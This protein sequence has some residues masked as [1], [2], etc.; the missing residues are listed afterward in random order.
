MCDLLVGLSGGLRPAGGL[1][2]FFFDR[3]SRKAS[4]DSA[5]GVDIRDRGGRRAGG[6]GGTGG[7]LRGCWLGDAVFGGCHRGEVVGRSRLFDRVLFHILGFGLEGLSAARGEYEPAIQ[8]GGAPFAP[9]AGL[10][11][12]RIGHA[13]DC[14]AQTDLLVADK[15]G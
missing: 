14:V 1:V 5:D 15:P 13:L 2:E 10:N 6:A 7:K 9:H 8:S 11:S 12:P 3:E 4:Y